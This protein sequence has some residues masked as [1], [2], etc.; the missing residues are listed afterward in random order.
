MK[1]TTN[2]NLK[3]PDLEDY[4]NVEDL[5]DNMDVIDT[6]MVGKMPKGGGDFTGIVKAHSNTSHSVRQIRNVIL[7]ASDAD[8]ALMQEGDIWMKYR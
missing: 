2:L 6:E 3:Q 8:V 1:Y 7:S 5:N 4:V